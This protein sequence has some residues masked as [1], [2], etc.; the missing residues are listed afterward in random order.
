MQRPRPTKVNSSLSFVALSFACIV[1]I[2]KQGCH[3]DLIQAISGACSVNHH[4]KL[5][6]AKVQ[7]HLID[8]LFGRSSDIVVHHK[9]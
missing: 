4:E 5:L 8:Q 2:P 9:K 6:L 7:N 3:P 1:T